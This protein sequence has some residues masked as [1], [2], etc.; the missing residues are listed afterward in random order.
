M[1]EQRRK[2]EAIIG[3]LGIVA[4]S[5][6]ACQKL[7]ALRITDLLFFTVIAGCIGWL[8]T[9]NDRNLMLAVVCVWIL[10]PL[11]RRMVDWQSGGFRPV[12]ALSV[13]PL[14]VTTSLLVP[15]YQRFDHFPRWLL[16]PFLLMG[17]PTAIA[18]AY[19]TLHYGPSSIFETGKWLLPFLLPFYL[20]NSD[21]FPAE[22]PRL[23]HRLGLVVGATALYA[24]FQYAFLPPWDARWL[25]ESE[26]TTSMG[27]PERFSVRVWGTMNACGPASIIW[28]FAIL[29]VYAK[30]QV[31]FSDLGVVACCSVALLISRV[32]ASWAIVVVGIGMLL[33]LLGSSLGRKIPL[34]AIAVALI[35]PL[36][37]FSPA[38]DEI[39]DRI[40]TM[41]DLSSDGSFQTRL[42]IA[43]TLYE[44]VWENPFGY[45]IGFRSSDKVAGASTKVVAID[46]GIG[47]LFYS[48]GL[49]GS[50]SWA[51]G[52]LTLVAQFYRL[53]TARYRITHELGALVFILSVV[54]FSRLI[55]NLSLIGLTGVVFWC[56]I[57]LW[58][59]YQTSASRTLAYSGVPA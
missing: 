17:V 37:I 36:F 12:T 25:V 38:G 9:R 8:A 20:V 52:F 10:S 49:I 15:I 46:N 28:A 19:G 56:L 59:S 43:E 55:I 57:G 24:I 1:N 11:L 16:Q 34:T 13:L 23:L 29:L 35:I 2:I 32:R 31:Q 44:Q 4:I 47:E 51:V 6:A 50:T 40:E 39:S 18:G 45:G 14:T 22:T 21:H 27:R 53:L 48:L 30:K 58:C 33:I 7:N 54:M 26:M 41:S 3:Y 42:S 5:I